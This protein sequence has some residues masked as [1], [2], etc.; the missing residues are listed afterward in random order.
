MKGL[1]RRDESR[2]LT[3]K[4]NIWCLQYATLKGKL[5]VSALQW[6]LGIP[7]KGSTGRHPRIWKV[8]FTENLPKPLSKKQKQRGQKPLVQNEIL[9]RRLTAARVLI[10]RS[11]GSRLHGKRSIVRSCRKK[12]TSAFTDNN[13][14]NRKKHSGWHFY[15]I[16]YFPLFSPSLHSTCS[17]DQQT[18]RSG[19]GG[20]RIS[21]AE[22]GSANGRGAAAARNT[23]AQEYTLP[24]R[25][26]LSNVDLRQTIKSP[27]D[28]F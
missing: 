18:C 25:R 9:Q 8:Y 10:Y 14:S 23:R 5:T 4:A 2:S 28:I 12:K 13:N 26:R 1:W 6:S 21:G 3:W 22:L 27:S 19:G 20:R 7:S 15:Q 24:C 17:P 16:C 11:P